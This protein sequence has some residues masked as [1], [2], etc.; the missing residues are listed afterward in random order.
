[1]DS[2]LK[3]MIKDEIEDLKKIKG[4]NYSEIEELFKN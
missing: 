2:E 4:T 3:H 1:M